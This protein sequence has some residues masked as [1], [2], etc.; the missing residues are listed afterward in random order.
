MP[1]G[2]NRLIIGKYRFDKNGDVVGLRYVVKKIINGRPE[3]IE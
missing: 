1:Y 3:V 2:E